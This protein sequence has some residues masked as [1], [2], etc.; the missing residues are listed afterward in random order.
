[1]RKIHSSFPGND[2][3]DEDMGEEYFC[4]KLH[5]VDLAGS[6]RAKRTGT[7]GIRLKEGLY[8]CY[9]CFYHF[10]PCHHFIM[11][12]LSFTL[13]TG[14]HINKGLLALGN[15]ISALGDEKKRRDGVHI[16][17]RDSKLTRLLQVRLR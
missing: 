1:M 11:N 9:A 10:M 14:I 17:Y 4:A 8:N 13:L 5:L 6:E 16:P 3:P 7:D 12:I 2:I 15:V